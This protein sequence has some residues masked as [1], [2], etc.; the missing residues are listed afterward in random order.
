MISL[1]CTQD[2][3]S[4]VRKK[5]VKMVLPTETKWNNILIN[6]NEVGEKAGCGLISTSKLSVINNQQFAKYIMKR[7]GDKFARCSACEKYK[8]LQDAHS[9]GAKSHN[10][11]Q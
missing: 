3:D 11:H 10:K 9:I 2:T 5:V 4:A 1:K 8:G 6:V 7:L